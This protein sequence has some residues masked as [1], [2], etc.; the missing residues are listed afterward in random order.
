MEDSLTSRVDINEYYKIPPL[1]RHYSEIWNKEDFI[2]EHSQSSKIEKKRNGNTPLSNVENVESKFLHIDL[3]KH[4]NEDVEQC[5]YGSF[6][7]R[8][9]AALVDENIMAPMT[10]SELQDVVRVDD[11]VKTEKN[12]QSSSNSTSKKAPI[13]NYTKNLENAIKDELFA[14]GLIDSVID[15]EHD[16]EADDE[17]LSELRKCQSELKA[18]RS[19]NKQSV[20]KL[21]ARARTAMKK[22]DA[23]LKAKVVDGEV[24]DIFRRFTAMKAK[25]KGFSRKDRE[26]AWKAVR[27]REQ[28]WRMVDNNET[29]NEKNEKKD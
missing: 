17:I 13:L 3:S 16:F 12:S 25:K 2:E 22:Q 11:D 20:N 21:A 27:E 24:V 5:P 18:L 7:Q 29:S 1:G 14:L 6:T 28:L 4:Q 26:M 8:L 9:V 15:D 10:E 23:R 19:H